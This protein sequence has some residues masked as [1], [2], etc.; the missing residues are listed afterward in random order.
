VV[1]FAGSFSPT[2]AG[3][4]PEPSSGGCLLPKRLCDTRAVQTSRLLRLSP[5][6]VEPVSFAV[7][8]AQKLQAYFQDDLFPPAPTGDSSLTAA[9]WLGGA[10]AGPVVRDLNAA[11]LP[12]LSERPAEVKTVSHGQVT[13]QRMDHVSGCTVD[14]LWLRCRCTAG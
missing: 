12:L 10:S 9:A 11:G 4:A 6:R 14:A 2:G 7:P 5:T 13:K 1:A 8:R 3:Y